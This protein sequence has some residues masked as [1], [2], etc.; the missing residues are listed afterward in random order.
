MLNPSCLEVKS[1]Q[2]NFSSFLFGNVSLLSATLGKSRQHS[3]ALHATGTLQVMKS[4][5]PLLPAIFM[6]YVSHPN[7]K[8]HHSWASFWQW[9]CPT[10]QKSLSAWSM[11][12]NDPELAFSKFGNTFFILHTIESNR[13]HYECD[14]FFILHLST[15]LTSGPL[16]T[17]L[18]IAL[19]MLMTPK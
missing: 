2:L 9:P 1:W 19:I 10:F 7:V 17:R 5:P 3:R 11:T 13:S 8:F 15:H 4:L 12:T 16:K 18:Y 6:K 14:I